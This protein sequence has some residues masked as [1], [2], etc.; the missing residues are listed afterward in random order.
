M[1]KL[2]LLVVSSLLV[3]LNG[4]AYFGDSNKVS[5]PRAQENPVAPLRNPPGMDV[6][7]NTLYPI[8]HNNYPNEVR[9][10]NISPPGLYPNKNSG[11]SLG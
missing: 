5:V 3:G 10:V 9:Q 8:P 6:S 1:R 4:C 2:A 7:Y 11:N